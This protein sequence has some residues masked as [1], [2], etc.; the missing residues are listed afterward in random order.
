MNL[1]EALCNTGIVHN[2]AT[3]V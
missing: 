3:I 2:W 1:E